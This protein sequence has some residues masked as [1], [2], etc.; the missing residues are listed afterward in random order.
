M[1]RSVA[2]LT[3]VASL[4]VTV[5]PAQT[6]RPRRIESR[7]SVST[8]TPRGVA[9]VETAPKTFAQLPFAPAEVLSY[10]VDWNNYVTAAQLELT[11]NE[12][13]RFFGKYSAM[14]RSHNDATLS[15][16]RADLRLP[17]GSSP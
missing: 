6:E 15:A 14:N 7:P 2:F 17:S 4:F 10:T 9:E 16:A 8:R 5:A 1:L 3:I 13:G 11:V 12:R